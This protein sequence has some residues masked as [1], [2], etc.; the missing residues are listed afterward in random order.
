[1]PWGTL[2]VG[3]VGAVPRVPA[4]APYVTS[5]REASGVP[6]TVIPVTAL[7][8]TYSSPVGKGLRVE[9]QFGEPDTRT[10][11]VSGGEGCF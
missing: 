10:P 2:Q 11:C 6:S 7:G 4:A 5:P 1:M 8:S 9:Q 3:P